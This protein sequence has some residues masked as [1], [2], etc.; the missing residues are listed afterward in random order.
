MTNNIMALA[1]NNQQRAK[2]VLDETK[3]LEIW[4]AAG[5][6]AELVGSVRMGLLMRNP[7]IDMH[8]YCNPFSL[9]AGFEAISRLALNP[10]IRRIEYTNLLDAEDQCIEWH[11][12]Y[13]NPD[14]ET[15][16]IDMIQIHMDSPYAGYF[17][18]VADAIRDKLTPET[19]QI[20]LEIKYAVPD[21]QKVMGI[22]IYQAVLRDG[23]RNYEEFMEW[24]EKNPQQEIITWMP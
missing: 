15:W 8:V 19:K 7:D 11:A 6:Q 3:I 16:Q 5:L 1:E 17:E 23:I 22:E 13:E 12:W 21:G 18:R 20:I 24:K 10:R 2:R 14:G 4:A 9:T